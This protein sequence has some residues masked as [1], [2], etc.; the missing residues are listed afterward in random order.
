MRAMWGRGGGAR[1]LTR[2]REGLEGFLGDGA[3]R[4]GPRKTRMTRKGDAR[5][6][7]HARARAQRVGQLIQQGWGVAMEKRKKHLPAARR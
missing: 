7:A 1:G 3:R 6:H 5:A 4:E 2:S